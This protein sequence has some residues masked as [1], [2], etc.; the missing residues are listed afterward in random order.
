MINMKIA[1]LFAITLL[2]AMAA[3]GTETLTEISEKVT[4]S[5]DMETGTFA[6]GAY[7]T[8]LEAHTMIGEALESGITD[9]NELKALGAM[10]CVVMY[11]LTCLE[12]IDGNND[13]AFTWLEGAIDAGYA[14]PDWRA[15]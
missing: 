6:E 12:A 2:V 8:L 1:S 11:N 13:E 15:E 10:D 7:E 3:A 5:F 4:A 14:D 9:V